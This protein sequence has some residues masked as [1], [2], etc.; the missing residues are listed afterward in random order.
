M[1]TKKLA[2]DCVRLVGGKENVISV[3][4][5]ATRLR[6]QLK[7]MGKAQIKEIEA[8]KDVMA[9]KEVGAQTQ[10]II[11]PNVNKVYDEVIKLVGD[12]SENAG[13]E[14]EEKQKLSAK[15]LDMV[16]GIFAPI[17][18][19]ITGAGMIKAV[20][21]ILVVLGLPDTSQEYYIL[22]FIAD[23]AFYFFPVVLGFSSARKFGCNPYLAAMIGGVLLH[24]NWSALVTAGDP[25][26]FFGIPV[27]LFSYSS[28]VL[29]II[30]TVW[31]MSYVERFAD[32]YSPSIVKAILKPLVTLAVTSLVALIIIA[33]LGAY[34]GGILAKGIAFLD[35]NAPALV[36]T[37]VGGVQPFLV[38]FGMH[39]A[40]FPPLQTIQLADMGY[41]IVTGPGF[42]A[43]NLAIAGATM[44]IAVRSK[45]RSVKELAFS[46][47]FTALCGITEPAIYGTIV[48]FKRAILAVI[49]GGVSGGLFAG[50]FHLKRYAIATPGIPALPTFIGEDPNNILFA[51]GTVII[52]FVVSFAVA[53]LFGIK[54]EPAAEAPVMEKIE[55]ENN[56]I[57]SPI[58]GN[59][60]ERKDIPDPTF[61]GGVLG[62]GVGIEPSEPRVYAPFNGT[63]VMVADT[64][65]ALGLQ[66]DDGIQLLI[67]VGIDTVDMNGDGFDV[68][69]SVGDTIQCGQTLLEFDPEKI[70]KAGHPSVTAVLVGN[71]EDYK[72]VTITKTGETKAL[73]KIMVAEP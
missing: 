72:K 4:H 14:N 40:I 41:E 51:V 60:I 46:S 69:C 12:L 66:S 13:A 6:F 16:S 30:L 29:P 58:N 27:K 35:T 39:L 65:H 68:K 31:F 21:T 56:T 24:P 47:G 10:I 43:A 5:C 3:I 48:K 11:G 44:G 8:L 37:I 45:N 28:S 32:K 53:Y 49:I 42:L 63:V 67:H 73:D 61:A 23:S 34:I 57:Y 52:A 64:R 20:L 71:S 18:P 22:N 59:V 7:D 15:I 62:E 38:F 55:T 50:I 2:E 9:V 1:D 17:I 54:D 33:P 26:S 70:K 19:L 25:V 36:P